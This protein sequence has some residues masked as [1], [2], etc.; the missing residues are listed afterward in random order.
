MAGVS[1]PPCVLAILEC[2]LELAI[3]VT[4]KLG[5]SLSPDR[6]RAVTITP[7]KGKGCR[8]E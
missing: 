6:T 2:L 7:F 8:V 5:T 4:A 3:C 1:A